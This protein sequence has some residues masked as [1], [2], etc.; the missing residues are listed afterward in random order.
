V[1]RGDEEGKV[2]GKRDPAWR[3][4]RVSMR[5]K[6][7]KGGGEEEGRGPRREEERE[8]TLRIAA[9]PGS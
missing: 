7:G 1:E 9:L 6:E 4:G 5:T 2:R 8:T 3:G